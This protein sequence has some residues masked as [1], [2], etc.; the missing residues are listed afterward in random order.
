MQLVC[1]I[2]NAHS[3]GMKAEHARCPEFEYQNSSISVRI[4]MWR[5]LRG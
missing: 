3:R 4:E 2:E 5:S 1:W